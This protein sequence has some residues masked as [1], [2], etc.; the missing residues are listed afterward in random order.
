M[1]KKSWIL[2]TYPKV[3]LAPQYTTW[4]AKNHAMGFC[5]RFQGGS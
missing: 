1:P 2:N 3:N 5:L 4:G